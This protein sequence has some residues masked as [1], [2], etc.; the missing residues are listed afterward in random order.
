[1][2]SKTALVFLILFVAGC[3]ATVIRTP[4]YGIL[5]YEIQYFFNPPTQWWYGDLPTIRYSY[6]V[7]CLV[8]IGYLLRIPSFSK[9]SLSELPQFRWLMLLLAI[10]FITY[11]W[12]VSPDK[13]LDYINRLLKIILFALLAYK[14]VDTPRKMDELLLIYICGIFYFSWNARN[15]GRTGEG[16]L[17][18]SG[19]A[20][21]TDSNGVAAVVV[22]AIPFLLFYLLYGS[23]RW[24]KGLS[25]VA[26]AFTLNSLVLL[27]SR[28]AFIALIVGVAYFCWFVLREKV[29]K[30]VRSKLIYG[31]LVGFC[32]FFYMT[33]DVFWSRMST[34]QEVNTESGGGQRTQ[35]WLKTFDMLKDYPLGAGAA[36]YQL[37]SPQYLPKEWLSGGERAV[38]STW[39][40][41]LSEYGFQGL[42]VFIGYILSGFVLLRKVRQVLRIQGNYYHFFQS[43]SLEASFI[44]LLVAATFVNFL[45]AE[46]MY[47]LP[48]YMGAFANI[49]L[50]QKYQSDSGHPSN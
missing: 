28:G 31:L 30:G 10:V 12:A 2:P 6:L 11:F 4:F 5:L 27:N 13:H 37:L 29:E 45:Y 36:G 47:W 23:T 42:I 19:F 38:H 24:I 33:D 20:D 50:F 35:Y 16:R 14:I 18:G 26:L 7:M 48:F 41:A 22:T 44:S 39:F 46:L 25:F 17:E 32:L 1:M 49:H 21:Y 40:E 3:V 43:V 9:N 8:V 34:I 15:M